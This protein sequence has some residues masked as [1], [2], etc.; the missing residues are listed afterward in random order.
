[1]N[2]PLLGL[3]V[4]AL[5][6]LLDGATAKFTSPDPVYQEALLS[7]ALGSSFK[8]LLGGLITGLVARRTGSLGFG[9]VVGL[10]AAVALST[11]VAVM[12]ANYYDDPSLYWKII[13]PGA[14][15]G[16]IVGY[17]VVRY[18]RPPHSKRISTAE[19]S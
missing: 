2:R 1:M 4:G 17:A 5:V 18:G 15:T 16:L 8:G 6:G 11:V 12:N 7:I 14:V 10:G 3:I 19:S 9:M 13:A